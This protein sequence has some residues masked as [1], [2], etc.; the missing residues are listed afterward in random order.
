MGDIKWVPGWEGLYYFS[1]SCSDHEI[2]IIG[3]ASN[4]PVKWKVQ[5]H[6]YKT[7]RAVLVK[8]LPDGRREQ[9]HLGLFAA[10]YMY[11]CGKIPDDFTVKPIDD[12]I[13]NLSEANLKLVPKRNGSRT[14]IPDITIPSAAKW[15]PGWEHLY[16]TLP[17]IEN[18]GVVDIWSTHTMSTMKWSID[19]NG[20]LITLLSFRDREARK[21]QHRAT[22]AHHYGPI[23]DGMYIDHIDGDRANNHINN[24]RLATPAQN[25]ANKIQKAGSSGVVGVRKI[26]GRYVAKIQSNNQEIHLGAY[27]TLEEAAEARRQ[28]EFQYHG[29][30]SFSKSRSLN[31][32]FDFDFGHETEREPYAAEDYTLD[33]DEEVLAYFANRL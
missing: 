28:G 9:L 22:Y 7:P 27:D 14:I 31:P 8:L 4:K 2:T 15:I 21:S 16:Y 20:Y 6:R 12:D 19:T 25:A 32:K 23:P 11:H 10:A 33:S 5:D 30:Y 17:S 13:T 29:D 18:P 26:L 3:R 1:D 24:L